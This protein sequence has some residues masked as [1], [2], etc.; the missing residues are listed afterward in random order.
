MLIEYSTIK[1]QSS[2]GFAFN[3]DNS[4]PPDRFPN[5]AVRGYDELLHANAA[6][7][8]V[9]DVEEWLDSEMFLCV[10]SFIVIS[11]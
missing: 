4:N 2:F 10:L 3:G 7:V 5:G 1:F 11:S 9:Q 8:S 6:P